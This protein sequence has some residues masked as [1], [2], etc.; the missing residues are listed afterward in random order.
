MRE[1]VRHDG[2]TCSFVC[3][4]KTRKLRNTS[5]FHTKNNY[6]D[7]VEG[8]VEN[9]QEKYC[10][11]NQRCCVPLTAVAWLQIVHH[12]IG[13]L[14]SIRLWEGGQWRGYCTLPWL[15]GRK[16]RGAPTIVWRDAC[17]SEWDRR[18]SCVCYY[19]CEGAALGDLR[20]S[21]TGYRYSMYLSIYMRMHTLVCRSMAANVRVCVCVCV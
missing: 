10:Y 17:V 1:V 6:S 20:E 4:Y 7:N 14:H 12:R 16:G 19:V 21:V 18:G 15:L 3:T 13:T 11:K 2:S 9:E 8:F 5:K